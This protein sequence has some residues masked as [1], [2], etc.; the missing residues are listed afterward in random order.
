M[1]PTTHMH[2]LSNVL[3]CLGVGE[4]SELPQ[5]LLMNELSWNLY[6][7][8]LWVQCNRVGLLGRGMYS[9]SFLT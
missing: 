5:D 4:G 2:R 9:H 8:E 7:N 6:M 3:N 1:L